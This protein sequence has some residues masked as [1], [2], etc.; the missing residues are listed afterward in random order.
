[1]T[2]CPRTARELGQP[3]TDEQAVEWCRRAYNAE[4]C[5]GCDMRKQLGVVVE[6][7]ARKE[8]REK[9]VQGRLF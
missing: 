8:E 3:C 6:P 5:A 9:P 7:A 4:R 2:I 1:M